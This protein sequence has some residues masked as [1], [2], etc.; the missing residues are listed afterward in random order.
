MFGGLYL[1][2][3]KSGLHFGLLISVRNNSSLFAASSFLTV[4]GIYYLV[5]KAKIHLHLILPIQCGLF[6]L[7]STLV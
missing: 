2:A 1:A 5:Y 6:E 3:I 4:K 7:P